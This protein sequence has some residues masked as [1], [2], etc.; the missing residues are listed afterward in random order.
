MNLT[1]RK[2]P[3]M[4]S[5]LRQ[6]VVTGFLALA[7]ATL[8][9]SAKAD[10][11][12]NGGFELNGGGGQ[13]AFNTSATGWTVP[14]LN[15]SYFF[16]F[17]PGVADGPG[18]AGEYGN[19]QLWGPGN[20]SAN[21]LTPT[22][23][24]G[25]SYVGSDPS[26]Q[27]GPLSQTINGLTAGSHY[28]LGFWWAA[29]QQFPFKGPTTE[30]WSV[31]LGGQTQSTAIVNNASHGFVPWQHQTFKYTAT[32]S[33]EVLSF[34]ATGGPASTVP[35]F[36]LLDGVTLTPTP[37][38]ESFTLVFSALGLIGGLGA[39]RPRNWFKR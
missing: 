23:P 25:G 10:L 38:P 12:T 30:G 28:T 5:T 13:L 3:L 29:A 33:S 26:F 34:L 32:S 17:T 27:N 2:F 4:N 14:A 36:A 18:V 37:E 7:F 39:L 22:S 9:V 20:G 11:V 15:G 1:L 24:A 19:F 21:G 35:P 6:A 31:T 16:L 8:S